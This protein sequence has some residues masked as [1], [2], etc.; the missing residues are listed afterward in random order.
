MADPALA[1]A[2]F[3]AMLQ[4]A[5]PGATLQSPL[6]IPYCDAD[7]Q[8]SRVCPE[9]ALVCQRPVYRS[10]MRAWT[11]PETRPEAL[12]RWA[13]IAWGAAAV[14][15]S[16]PQ[17]WPGTPRELALALVTIARFES[18]FWRS[19]QVGDVTG[20]GGELCL[21]QIHAGARIPEA[22]RRATVGLDPEALERCFRWGAVL[23]TRARVKCGG[24]RWFYRAASLYGT[25]R[26]C[27][28]SGALE[29]ERAFCRVSQA[30]RPLRDDERAVFELVR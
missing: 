25:G 3:G 22:E 21:V 13:G 19:V 8:R 9:P 24:R 16:P 20:P 1:A 5:Q 7:C 17:G 11:R 15:S 12:E 18:A 2:V 26:T 27:S 30:P 14:A 10:K 29:R 4:L 23:L 6:P 28:W